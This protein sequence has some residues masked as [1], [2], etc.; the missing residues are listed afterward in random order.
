MLSRRQT[1][2]FFS[3]ANTVIFS[4]FACGWGGCAGVDGLSGRA[5]VAPA[6]SS[7]ATRAQAWRDAE[8]LAAAQPGRL[9]VIGAGDSMRPVYGENT[10]LV[11]QA[12]DFE[13]LGAGMNV[14]YRDERGRVVLHR[15]VARDAGGWR[16]I[17][18]NN[19]REDAGRV[20]SANLLGVVYAAFAHGEVE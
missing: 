16:A 8:A 3:A 18:L 13:S 6:P 9:T 2:S 20:T 7:E 11:L 19:E 4:L 12:V 5:A 10:V 14:A 17:G 1:P 15:L